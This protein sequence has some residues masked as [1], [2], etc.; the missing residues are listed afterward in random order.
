ML[1]NRTLR[2]A[3]GLTLPAVMV[4]LLLVFLS[5]ATAQE[6]RAASLPSLASGQTGRSHTGDLII[7]GTQEFIIQGETFTQTGNIIVRDQG[8]LIVR[9]GTLFFQQGGHEAYSMSFEDRGALILDNAT[10]ASNF[11][12]E[13]YL[14]DYATAVLTDSTAAWS[15]FTP[16]EQAAVTATNS[17]IDDL[18]GQMH[19]W[20]TDYA[21][22]DVRI[23]LTDC[24]VHEFGLIFHHQAQ[25]TLS[26]I[27]PNVEYA[28]WDLQRDNTIQGFPYQISL[29]RST[30]E[31]WNTCAEDQSVITFTASTLHQAGV[32]NQASLTLE[33]CSVLDSIDF[34]FFDEDV[35]ISDIHPGHI[36][37]WR[38]S[39]E[40]SVPPTYDL[41]LE[42]CDIAGWSFRPFGGRLTIEN[43][44]ING[45]RPWLD[46]VVLIRDSS[47]NERLMFWDYSGTT[48]FENSVVA[49]WRDN[50]RCNYLMTGTVRFENAT[51]VDPEIGPWEE[52]TIHRQYPVL[53]TVDGAPAPNAELSLE[54]QSGSTVW[55][56][57]TDSV[58]TAIFTLTFTEANYLDTWHLSATYQ[59]SSQ[60]QPVTISSTTP[61]EF[62]LMPTTPTSTPTVTETPTT[63]PTPTD[64]PTGMPTATS[65]PTHTPTH[66]PTATPT[67]SPTP[68]VTPTPTDTPTPT[69]TPTPT[70]TPTPTST[71]TPL[72]PTVTGVE[73]SSGPGDLFTEIAIFGSNFLPTPSVYLDFT[74]LD[75][76]TF[77]SSVELQAIVPAGLSPGPYDVTVTNPDGQSGVLEAGYT[78][79]GDWCSGGPW[80]GGI[81][82]VVVD[83]IDSQMVYA[84]SLHGTAAGF[85]KSTDGGGH[86]FPANNGLPRNADFQDLEI[87]PCDPPVLIGAIQGV[88]YRSTDRAASWTRVNTGLD[89]SMGVWDLAVAASPGACP[90]VDQLVVYAAT[91]DGLYRSLD[92][93][94]HWQPW[95]QGLPTPLFSVAV[96]ES[97]WNTLY[98]G[99]CTGLVY[100]SSDGGVT[101]Q[102]AGPGGDPPPQFTALEISP[103]DPNVVFGGQGLKDGSLPCEYRE[104]NSAYFTVDGGVSWQEVD[105]GQGAHYSTFDFSFDRQNPGTVCAATWSGMFCSSDWGQ[106]WQAGMVEEGWEEMGTAVAMGTSGVAYAGN[107]AMGVMKSTDYGRTWHASN[108]GLRAIVPLSVEAVP[109]H[110]EV[111][112]VTTS[113]TGNFR[114]LDRGANWEVMR[115]GAEG[116][117]V[118]GGEDLEVVDDRGGSVAYLVAWNRLYQSTD[119]GSNWVMQEIPLAQEKG[120]AALAAHPQTPSIVYV[121]TY[122]SY[123]AEI[124]RSTDGGSSWSMTWS[125]EDSWQVTSIAVPPGTPDRVYAT[126]DGDGVLRSTDGGL[127]WAPCNVGLS[128][129]ST[130]HI[131]PDVADPDR[132]Y[133]ATQGAGIYLTTDGGDH[134]TPIN[135]GLGDLDPW[136]LAQDPLM[137]SQLYAA[138]RH[139]LYQS[140]DA[141]AT[142]SLM[143]GPLSQAFVFRV[144]TASD[145]RET[146]V[147]CGV[148]GSM[149]VVAPLAGA[150]QAGALADS[151]SAG[152]GVYQMTI[153]HNRCFGDLNYDGGID[154]A[155]IMAVA[156]RWRCR[157]GDACY[158]SGK[159]LDGDG[160][161]DIVDIMLVA[162]HWGES[163]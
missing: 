124:W 118:A 155:D 82:Y 3:L 62:N 6:P 22:W 76:V 88:V 78:V 14:D 50:R 163:C 64:T 45:L 121:G 66:T 56:G 96:A 39:E 91:S 65:T 107:A 25:G 28:D 29:V 144:S 108:H 24:Q 128:T 159:D 52:A 81:G 44:T 54:T 35:L 68:T 131:L 119:L 130:L 53:V 47:I 104:P 16:R 75:E 7:S 38:L 134:W 36:D 100:R 57:T 101:W 139:G 150:A 136:E 117:R 80:G 73:P 59:G 23:S 138:S 32:Q 4:G 67:L 9:D 148:K 37:H 74:Q 55:T 146:T 98:V 12:H 46:A 132:L 147:Y 72:P 10:I 149:A 102:A 79:E 77:V 99:A 21:G 19:N 114:T 115:F 48:G 120:A 1:R 11:R 158:E 109:G 151:V 103:Q 13:L 49:D 106:N 8:K 84:A 105:F 122:G 141:G 31:N 140:S 58:G 137:P 33:D 153:V 156:S 90:P 112:F 111:A 51:I 43:S 2:L 127:S 154:V 94:S 110:P 113:G 86:W 15:M 71:P 60:E 142:W 95:G 70:P 63:T 26:G 30:V 161:I 133:V 160:D 162:A 69:E 41:L 85:F 116:L 61:V 17:Y 126:T 125:S 152:S 157:V 123:P 135:E 5:A 145:G 143:P 87:T 20:P 97:A 42:N 40:Q 89:Q 83:P 27:Q 93:G 92:G 18:N 129:L 34:D